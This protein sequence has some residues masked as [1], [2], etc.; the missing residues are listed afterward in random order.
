MLLE[1]CSL[2]HC[3]AARLSCH[4]LP[5]VG[6]I[7]LGHIAHI[8]WDDIGVAIPAFLTM[9]LMP[10]TYSGGW[11]GGWVAES[12]ALK[13]GYWWWCGVACRQVVLLSPRGGLECRP[14]CLPCSTQPG[15]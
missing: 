15:T 14:L 12:A 2:H 6:T 1:H 5:Q 9:T 11:V 4:R 10:F 3:P 8:E 7:L 13:R